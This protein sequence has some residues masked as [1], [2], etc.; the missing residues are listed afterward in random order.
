[1]N[2]NYHT[3]TP[4]CRHA[5][6][7]AEEYVRRAVQM[8]VTYMGFSDHAPYRHADGFGLYWRVQPEELESYISELSEIR[9]RYRDK[10]DLKIG[11]EM[12]YYPGCFEKM[13]KTATEC[14]GEYLILGQHFVSEEDERSTVNLHTVKP[15]DSV[16]KLRAYADTVT[17][18]IR[19]GKFTYVAHPD[20]MN[21]T[22][23]AELYR[24]EM[25]KICQ[26]SLE[27]DIPLEINFL[28]IREMRNYPCESFWKL[29]GEVGS[30]VTFGFDAH[31]A[32]DAFDE[33]SLARAEELVEKYRLN[34]I[35]RPRVILI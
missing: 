30:P 19:T 23:D 4:Y 18:G 1:M 35:G 34:Y 10:I 12:E 2:Y 5:S 24:E 25:R 9:E 11:F 31:R 33:G 32:V 16:E 27:C 15:S 17:E 26:A 20:I 7:T 3:H 6:N 28:G 14:G 21:F 13:Q 22:G 8:G 29:A